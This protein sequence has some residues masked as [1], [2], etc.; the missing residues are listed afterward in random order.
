[1]RRDQIGADPTP[2]SRHQLGVFTAAAM[3]LCLV[4]ALT[5]DVWA[6]STGGRYGGRAGFSQSRR[7]FEDDRGS[8]RSSR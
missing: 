7:G 6:R 2:D 1:M 3:T 5:S 4:L 8:R